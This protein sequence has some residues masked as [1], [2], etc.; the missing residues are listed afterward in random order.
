M[1][2]N[3]AHRAGAGLRPE[4]TLAAIQMASEL[5][6]DMIEFDIQPTKDSKIVLMHDKT[7][8][9]TTNGTGKPPELTHAYLMSL[10]AGS[11]FHY[12]FTGEKIPAL[13][14]ALKIVPTNI[15]LNVELKY[16][17]NKGDWF[18]RR[19]YS[20]LEENR[21]L[22]RS[23]ITTRWPMT[24]ERL[25]KIDSDVKTT[26]LQ[27][28]RTEDEYLALL[29]NQQLEYAQIRRHSMNQPFIDRLH[30]NG[31]QVFIFYSDEEKE[32]EKFARMGVDGILTN[33]PDRL[34]KVKDLLG[35]LK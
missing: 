1:V 8:D 16:F 24:C 11:W 13:E 35:G 2:K 10:D 22:K 31:I 30:D 27:K 18:E 17:D 23:I 29:V 20:I 12:D 33:F 4:N 14:E 32:M 5:N 25:L 15:E 26:V 7:V 6:V 9:R 21:A 19:V 28:Q 3:I 34:C